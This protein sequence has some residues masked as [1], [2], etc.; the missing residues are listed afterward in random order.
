M[1]Q[2]DWELLDKQ[3][4][5]FSSRPP[6]NSNEVGLV[7]VS[8]FLAGMIAGGVLFAHDSSK[9]PQVASRD[10]MVAYSLLDGGPPTIR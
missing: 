3:L 6:Q 7:A 10:V 5:G 1:N 2:R 8:V 9:H 4:G